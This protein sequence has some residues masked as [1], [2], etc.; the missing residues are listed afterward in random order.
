MSRIVRYI[1][2]VVLIGLISLTI[3][4]CGGGGHGSKA[5]DPTPIT[6]PPQGITYNH[7]VVVVLE[8]QNYGDIVGNTGA[9]PYLNSLVSKGALET[10]YFSN[11][12]KSLSAHMM[13]AAGKGFTDLTQTFTDDNIVRQLK[14]ANKT[15]KFYAQSLPE[16]GY[17]G[18]DVLPYQQ[19]HNPFAF[20]SDVKNDA[21]QAAN[22][23]KFETHFAADLTA[24]TLPNYAYLIPDDRNS[25]HSC[26]VKGVNCTNDEK[27]TA[28]DKWL[29]NNIDPLLKNTSFQQDGLLI[30]VWDSSQTDASCSDGT[31]T[32]GGKVV[33]LILG[34]KVKAAYQSAT[35]AGHSSTLRLMAE[36][37]G[38]TSFP[39]DAASAA[40]LDDAFNK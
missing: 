15:W 34:P 32:C 4:G 11:S 31:T 6:L 26:P 12:Q 28:A 18:A 20:M 25:G 23:V 38:L 7:A 36:T 8:N 9:M 22:I 35:K 13:L 16:D 1:A 29:Q 5:S 17:L 30:I 14:K 10:Q 19:T 3:S 2:T 24:G 40:N 21:A 37:I 33:S 27:L 39:N